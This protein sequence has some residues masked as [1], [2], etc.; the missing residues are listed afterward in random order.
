VDVLVLNRTE[1]CIKIARPKVPLQ[2]KA[3]GRFFAGFAVMPQID[4]ETQTPLKPSDTELNVVVLCKSEMA[5]IQTIRFKMNASDALE[6]AVRYEYF[7]PEVFGRFGIWTAKKEVALELSKSLPSQVLEEIERRQ[8]RNKHESGSRN[9]SEA[10]V[11]RQCLR[12]CCHRSIQRNSRSSQNTSGLD[13]RQDRARV[14][15]W[16]DRCECN[17]P[18]RAIT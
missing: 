10:A 12:A 17:L 6:K 5:R 4:T 13:S 2:E 3:D 9:T 7:V 1:E 15:A 18:V 8:S 11:T 14:R 16:P